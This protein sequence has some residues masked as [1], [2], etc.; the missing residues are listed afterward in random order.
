MAQARGRPW[1]AFP[2]GTARAR[3]RGRSPSL[4]WHGK[5][6][7]RAGLDVEALVVRGAVQ[8]RGAA[9]RA[10]RDASHR[11]VAR[12]PAHRAVRAKHADR[13]AFGGQH[14]HLLK[15][16]QSLSEQQLVV[17]AKLALRCGQQCAASPRH[18]AAHRKILIA[19]PRRPAARRGATCG[20][21]H[22][23]TQRTR[24]SHK[25]GGSAAQFTRLQRPPSLRELQLAAG[26]RRASYSR[27]KQAAGQ[28]C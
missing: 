15:L 1:N 4:A 12:R 10:R 21:R 23:R 8:R 19:A 7:R 24:S 14:T 6:G 9:D 3:P 16:K 25:A 11:R 18:E 22:R 27:L 17:A 2:G 20:R 28:A 5:R 13:G 26:A